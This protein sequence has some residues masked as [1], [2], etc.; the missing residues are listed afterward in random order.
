MI[1]FLYCREQGFLTLT[2]ISPLWHYWPLALDN[3]SLFAGLCPAHWRMLSGIPL[4]ASSSFLPSCDIKTA[5]RHCQMSPGRHNHPGW[6]HLPWPVTSTVVRQTLPGCHKTL[7]YNLPRI[8]LFASF[9]F[10]TVHMTTS[11]EL[12]KA[13]ALMGR[14]LFEKA[15]KQNYCFPGKLI[16]SVN[17][18]SS[19]AKGIESEML[20]HNCATG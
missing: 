18:I 1:W 16:F 14:Y 8:F 17:R 11:R 5:S 19:Y 9:F 3:S 6:E 2:S 15:L 20:V 4:K 12:F 7:K 10:W 13:N